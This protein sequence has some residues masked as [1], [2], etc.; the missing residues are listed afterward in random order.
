V[1]DVGFAELEA[2]DGEVLPERAALSLISISGV[3]LNILTSS[4]NTS[5]TMPAGTGSVAYACQATSSPGTPGLLGDLGVG[6]SN[7]S[8]GM[9]C[10]PAAVIS[11]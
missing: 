10:M 1:S 6:S 9:T 4:S 11:H 7:A 2:L 3:H 8:S 5:Y